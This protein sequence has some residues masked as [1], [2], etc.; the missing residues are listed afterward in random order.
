MKI[1]KF[2]DLEV[3]KESHKLTLLIYQLTEKFPKEE[4]YALVSQLRR[5][6]VSVESCIA[7]GFCRY[8]YK[9]RLTFYFDARG[10]IGEIQSQLITAKDLTYIADGEFANAY[11]QTEKVGIILGGLIR[12]TMELIRKKKST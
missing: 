1:E 8:H 2:T 4:V 5:A 6:S 10:S 9:D 11:Q 12:S 7:E 3:W